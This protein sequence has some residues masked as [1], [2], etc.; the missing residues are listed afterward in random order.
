V[1]PILVALDLA[2]HF[3][4]QVTGRDV[5]RGKPDPE[6]YLT[7]AARLGMAPGACVVFEDAPVG[8]E[9]ARRAGMRVVGVATTCHAGT[10]QAA[11]ARVVV[12]DFAGL[13]WEDVVSIG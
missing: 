13:A 3:C 4:V 7:T 1:E 11:G 6:V 2:E 12:P 9:A 8:I 10:L 5:R